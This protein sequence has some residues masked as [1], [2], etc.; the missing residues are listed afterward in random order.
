MP[1]P[2]SQMSTPPAPER[3]L[4]G[5]GHAK[6]GVALAVTGERGRQG[7]ALAEISPHGG[8]L[9]VGPRGQDGEQPVLRV[10]L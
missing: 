9:R 1:V 6:L 3:R 4:D 8:S 5:F 7:P 2:A 10:T